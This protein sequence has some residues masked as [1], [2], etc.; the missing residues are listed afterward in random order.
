MKTEDGQYS[1]YL[2]NKYLPG[3]SFYLGRM[4]YPKLFRAFKTSD[5]IIDLGCGTGEFL[6][7]CR[8]KKREAIG[9]DSNEALARKCRNRGLNVL[10]DSI[11]ELTSLKG[12]QFKYAIC[13]NVL[14][15]LGLE[16]LNCFF[17]RMDSLLLPQG[18]LI[19]IVPGIRGFET[20]PTHKTFI[21]QSVLS[22]LLS[23]SALRISD[24]YFH[25]FNLR[26][27]DRYFY[28]NMQVFEISKT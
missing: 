5:P 12:R 2:E 14:E 4:F 10:K 1:E 3:R 18:V 13:D 28:L 19:C 15:H 11:C 23:K 21:S 9:V 8:S 27:L 17:E 6:N 25:P 24:Y 16:N 7:Y 22:Q 20:D 26:S